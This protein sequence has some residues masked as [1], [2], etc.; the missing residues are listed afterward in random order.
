ME[1]SRYVTE[2]LRVEDKIHARMLTLTVHNAS[3]S[4][5]F[6]FNEYLGATVSV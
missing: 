2:A 1:T 5:Y 6:L 4:R 3:E